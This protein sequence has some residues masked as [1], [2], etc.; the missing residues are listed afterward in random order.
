MD[1]GMFFD[2]DEEDEDEEA[3]EGVGKLS[4]SLK[5]AK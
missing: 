4:Q 3:E 2:E 5:Q 1:E